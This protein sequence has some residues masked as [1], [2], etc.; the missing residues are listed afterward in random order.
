MLEVKRSANR[1]VDLSTGKMIDA[2]EQVEGF[3]CYSAGPSLAFDAFSATVWQKDTKVEAL[4]STRPT[5]FNSDVHGYNFS[6]SNQA[7][8]FHSTQA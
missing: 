2:F 4:T 7:P 8:T 6:L 1:K 3:G 5:A